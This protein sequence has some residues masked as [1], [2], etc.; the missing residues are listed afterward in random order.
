[1]S[2]KFESSNNEEVDGIEDANK[3]TTMYRIDF[4]WNSFAD[5]PITL[6]DTDVCTKPSKRSNK[7]DEE[8]NIVSVV[9]S[10]AH[11]N[12]IHSQRRLN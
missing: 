11:T 5:V 7:S 1:M 6:P 10:T 3:E 8:T 4:N 2:V 9:S 12:W